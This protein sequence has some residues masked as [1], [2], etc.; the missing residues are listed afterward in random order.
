M[1]QSKSRSCE[2]GQR[3]RQ[4]RSAASPSIAIPANQQTDT[5]ARRQIGTIIHTARGS[6]SSHTVLRALENKQSRSS[7][8]P[9]KPMSGVAC[10][11]RARTFEADAGRQ[12]LAGSSSIRCKAEPS[13]TGPPRTHHASV[14]E[15]EQVYRGDAMV[16]FFSYVA[17][18]PCRTR[19]IRPRCWCLQSC[20]IPVDH[21][22]KAPSGMSNHLD[23]SCRDNEVV[24]ILGY[25]N[26]GRGRRR[27]SESESRLFFGLLAI[28]IRVDRRRAV[29]R[30]GSEDAPIIRILVGRDESFAPLCPAK[31][32]GSRGQLGYH[33]TSS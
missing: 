8:T 28:D 16:A 22:S 32:S 30:P 3:E 10:W 6:F 11:K 23:K 17:W 9:A 21:A 24:D 19:T 25:K 5:A 14:A 26:T 13:H 1:P 20:D 15:G 2:R 31:A 27:P 18:P 29:V 4:N 7:R 33:E 12:H